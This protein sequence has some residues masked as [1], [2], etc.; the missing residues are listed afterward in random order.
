MQRHGIMPRNLIE[1]RA[2]FSAIAAFTLVAA[3]AWATADCRDWMRVEFHYMADT[4]D[5]N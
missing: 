1:P 2:A 3:P 4:D 5:L